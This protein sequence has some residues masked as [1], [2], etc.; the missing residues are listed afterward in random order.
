M[1][2]ASFA[3]HSQTNGNSSG[4]CSKIS[5]KNKGDRQHINK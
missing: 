3:E 1:E 4:A 5:L 2:Q